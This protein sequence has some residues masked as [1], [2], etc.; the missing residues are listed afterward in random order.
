MNG[1]DPVLLPAWPKMIVSLIEEET[2]Q[3]K[4]SAG[5]R[6]VQSLVSVPGRTQEI[7]AS[8]Q[9][10]TW[11]QLQ[12]PNPSIALSR[13]PED[14]LDYLAAYELHPHRVDNP[15]PPHCSCLPL[16][17]R[18]IK[19]GETCNGPSCKGIDDD[20]TVLSMNS[21]SG[22]SSAY[23]QTFT[24]CSF[25]HG[26]L[27][28]HILELKMYDPQGVIVVRGIHRLGFKA[29]QL[30]ESYF[31]QYGQ[32]NQVRVPCKARHY[33]HKR[34]AKIKPS[35]I[36]FII[37]THLKDVQAVIAGEARHWISTGQSGAL[38]E[39]EVRPFECPTDCSAVYY[40]DS[41]RFVLSL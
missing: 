33:E 5:K 6:M 19:Q 25:P 37:M 3:K 15:M 22:S 13:P 40:P 27:K 8:V 9:I 36:G 32:V 26:S 18:M 11:N 16:P 14:Q 23:L 20:D 30:L 35:P 38:V 2:A 34:G 10:E 39:V 41:Q 12:L 29:S 17:R 24:A 4:S 1:P 31:S 21:P 28:H 7:S